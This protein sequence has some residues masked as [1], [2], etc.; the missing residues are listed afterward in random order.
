MKRFYYFCLGGKSMSNNSIKKPLVTA[1]GAAVVGTLSAT[2]TIAADNPFAMQQL[3][4]GYMQVA[5]EGK[6][7]EGKCGSSKAE[8]KP[9]EGKCGEGKCGGSGGEAKSAEGKCGG[10]SK[11]SEGSCGGMKQEAEKAAEGKCGEGKC[12]GSK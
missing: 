4:S 9:A 12:G 10:A 11:A 6:C 1:I 3:D 8:A 7:G 5:M 2:G